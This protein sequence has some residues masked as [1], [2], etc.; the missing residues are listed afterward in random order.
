M[1]T[2]LVAASIASDANSRSTT[3]NILNTNKRLLD[4]DEDGDDD[5]SYSRLAVDSPTAKRRKRLAALSRRSFTQ[6]NHALLEWKEISVNLNVLLQ[7][8]DDSIPF[9]RDGDRSSAYTFLRVSSQLTAIKIDLMSYAQTV[10][11]SFLLQSE[12]SFVAPDGYQLTLLSSNNPAPSWVFCFEFLNYI[13]SV[14]RKLPQFKDSAPTS[15]EHYVQ[16]MRTVADLY[17]STIEAIPVN[18]LV[19]ANAMVLEIVHRQFTALVA[20]NADIF[21]ST[22]TIYEQR[23]RSIAR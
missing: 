13:T 2:A 7:K 11:R 18:Q 10:V 20:N 9:S 1:A 23:L 21:Q 8:L 5:D 6:N 3:P 14:A 17:Q 15:N 4:N 16:V 12:V 22:L 19:S